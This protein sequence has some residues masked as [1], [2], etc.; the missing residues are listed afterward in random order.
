MASEITI[1][2]KTMR[3]RDRSKVKGTMRK[4]KVTVRNKGKGNATYAA[5]A[6]RP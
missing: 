3:K 5:V 4:K 6:K 1:K 2:K